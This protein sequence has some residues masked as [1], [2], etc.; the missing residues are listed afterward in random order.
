[1]AYFF[2]HSRDTRLIFLNFDCA[3]QAKVPFSFCL[4]GKWLPDPECGLMDGCLPHG[5][6][7]K[8]NVA[9]VCFIIFSNCVFS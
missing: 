8:K 5:K 7:Q 6:M 9:E 3:Q 2:V 4:L 1:M